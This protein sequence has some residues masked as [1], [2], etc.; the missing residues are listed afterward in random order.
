VWN[1]YELSWLGRQGQPRTALGVLRF[2]CSAP[3]IV[4]SKS[5][6]LYLGSYY[7][8][9]MRDAASVERAIA[10]DLSRLVGGSVEVAVDADLDRVPTLEAPPADEVRLDALDVAIDRFELA[11]ELLH[12]AAAR[13]PR[14]P[15]V[16]EILYTHA[17]RSLCPVTEQPDWATIRVGYEGRPIEHA[18]LLR[19][20][21]SFRRHADF[22][23]AC[24]E[25]IFWDLWRAW[26]P[27]ALCVEGRFVRRGGLDINPFRSSD[28][29]R[30][31]NLRTRRQ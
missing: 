8:E 7:Q 5:L 21:V 29:R 15:S 17:F 4:E 3:R 12:E 2:P 19:Y 23:E 20:L 16:R 24:V 22:H 1:A 30:A 11:P 10:E 25:R 13:A 14:R 18:A 9:R 6:K 27:D 26:Q 31:P 28:E